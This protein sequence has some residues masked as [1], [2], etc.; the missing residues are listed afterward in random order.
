MFYFFKIFFR[1]KNDIFDMGVPILG[2]RGGVCP[3]GNFSHVISFFLKTSL[4]LAGPRSSPVI[5]SDVTMFQV[6][7]FPGLGALS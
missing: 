4:N 6:T 5:I 7:L 1:K 2:G 3:R